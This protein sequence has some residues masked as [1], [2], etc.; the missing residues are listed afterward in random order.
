MLGLAEKIGGHKR[1][2][3]GIVRNDEDFR[4]AREQIDSHFAEELAPHQRIRLGAQ[5]M[6]HPS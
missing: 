1:H 2:V 5:R 6:G 4:W 3:C